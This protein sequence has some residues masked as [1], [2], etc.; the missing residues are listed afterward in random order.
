MHLLCFTASS[1]HCL[2]QCSHFMPM[3]YLHG[4]SPYCLRRLLS[5]SGCSWWGVSAFC[6]RRRSDASDFSEVD[7]FRSPPDSRRRVLAYPSVWLFQKGRYPARLLFDCQGTYLTSGLNYHPWRCFIFNPLL[8]N[9][10]ENSVLEKTS[11]M[12]TDCFHFIPLL[13]NGNLRRV[14]TGFLRMFTNCFYLLCNKYPLT[15]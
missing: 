11:S 12:F 7:I 1:D 6:C 13:P 4:L 8:L 2:L 3:L 15:L 5:R 14:L 10:H 9:G